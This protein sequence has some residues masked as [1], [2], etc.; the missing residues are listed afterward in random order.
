[1]TFQVIVRPAS[2][3]VIAYRLAAAVLTVAALA[4]FRL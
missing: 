4:A 2:H 1:M 3:R